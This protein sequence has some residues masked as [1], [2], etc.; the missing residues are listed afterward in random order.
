MECQVR[1][2]Q[3]AGRGKG[4][5]GGAVLGERTRLQM[6]GES[7]ALGVPAQTGRVELA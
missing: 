6:W 4:T 3:G 7:Q 5:D 1:W 2:G